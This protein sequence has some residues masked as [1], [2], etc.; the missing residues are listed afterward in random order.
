MK[1]IESPR[2]P[3]ESGAISSEVDHAILREHEGNL[4]TLFHAHNERYDT[5]ALLDFLDEFGP[6]RWQ[7]E[8]EGS[9][10]QQLSFGSN[11]LGDLFSIVAQIDNF[12]HTRVFHYNIFSCETIELPHEN[13]PASMDD[14][15]LAYAHSGGDPQKCQ[16]DTVINAK[17]VSLILSG[18]GN[19]YIEYS[20]AENGSLE[21]IHDQPLNDCRSLRYQLDY[22]KK[23]HRQ[24]SIGQVA[25][26]DVSPS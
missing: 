23:I 17:P 12:S 22:D 25:L 13:A 8:F 24:T 18:R 19:R 10:Y 7:K 14:G 4:R 11:Q 26:R 16:L 20:L 9:A 5:T 1:P 6:Q 15:D 21:K 3:F 2:R